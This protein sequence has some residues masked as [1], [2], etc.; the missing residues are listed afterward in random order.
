MDIN[1]FVLT[2]IIAFSDEAVDSPNIYKDKK[3][4]FCLLRKKGLFILHSIVYLYIFYIFKTLNA[5][6][7]TVAPNYVSNRCLK[8]NCIRYL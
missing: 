8:I 4:V 5:T 3:K 6:E 7:V 2:K 1:D